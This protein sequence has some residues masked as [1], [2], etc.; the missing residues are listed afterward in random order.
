[1]TSVKMCNLK[2]NYFVLY[3]AFTIFA[4]SKHHLSS[5]VMKHLF[6][7]TTFFS[8]VF[9]VSITVACGKGASTSNEQVPVSENDT[10]AIGQTAEESMKAPVINPDA[11]GFIRLS[12]CPTTYDKM[13]VAISE[14]NTTVTITYNGQQLQT[15]SDAE[16]GLV[17]T[18]EN[19][20]VHFMDANFDGFVDIFLGSGESRTYS[21]LLIWDAAAKQFKRIGKLGAPSFQNI[22]LYPSK[23][24][25]FDGG[26]NSWCSDFFT[27]HI[28]ENGDLKGVEEL[29]IVSDA[30]QYGEYDVKNKYTLRDEQQKDILSTDDISSLP[31]PWESVLDQYGSADKP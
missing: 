1:M 3:S 9:I 22:L 12:D 18:G 23:K 2:Y 31:S 28:W 6:N 24:Y 30:E 7:F 14:D 10:E 16:D 15:L 26:S 11:S 8:V 13:E 19:P 25:L 4:L 27:R 20:I 29:C 17:A 5:E 21:A